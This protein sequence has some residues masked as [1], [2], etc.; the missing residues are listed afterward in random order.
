[1]FALRHDRPLLPRG[2]HLRM[3]RQIRASLLRKALEPDAGRA[4]KPLRL[5]HVIRRAAEEGCGG[6]QLA[7]IRFHLAGEERLTRQHFRLE[8][9]QIEPPFRDVAD[10]S[11]IPCPQGRPGERF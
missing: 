1:M 3:T 11:K 2:L 4:A 6:I 10:V 8:L 7:R 5:E 9:F